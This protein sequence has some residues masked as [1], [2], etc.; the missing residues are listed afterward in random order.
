M[1]RFTQ[2]DICENPWRKKMKNLFDDLNPN[3]QDAVKCTEGPLLIL[4][5][6]GSGKTRVITYRIAYL[7][8]NGVSPWNILA[9]TFTNKAAAQMRER[10]NKL[11]GPSA[12]SVWISTYH[13]FCARVLR[14][15]A[16]H[17]GLNKD[18]TIYDDDDSKKIVEA[19]LKELNYDTGKFKPSVISGM[20]SSAKDKLLD[21]ESYGIH[22]STTPEPTS[23]GK[24]A[25]DVYELYQKK[26]K[27]ANAVDFGDLLRYVVELLKNNPPVLTKYQ[28]RFKYIMIDEYQDTNYAQYVLT[29]LLAAKYKNICVV[30]DDDQAI[31]SWRGADV[32]NIMEFERDYPKTTVVYLEQNYRSTKN[33]LE[34]AGSLISFNNHRKP[35]RLWT[36]R[37]QG[38]DVVYSEFR[39]EFN[40][41]RNVA[42]KIKSMVEAEGKS[43]SDFAVFYRTNAQ[44]R[45]FEETLTRYGIPF[46]VVGSQRFYERAEVKDILGYLKLINNPADS[47]SFKRIINIP[48]RGIGKVTLTSIQDN[49]IT[50]GK[51]LTL[52]ESAK[53]MVQNGRLPKAE[54]FIKLVD[55]MLKE[56]E[57]MDASEIAKIVIDETGYIQL[58]EAQNDI[59]SRSR[60]ENIQ[61]LVSAIVDFE[62]NSQIKTLP[63]FLENIA[64]VSD[65]DVWDEKKDFVTLITLHLAKGLEFPCVFLTG[66]EEGLFPVGNSAYSMEEL[67]EERRLCYVGMTRAKEHL[68]LS[69]A[70]QRRVY[71]QLRWCIPSRFVKE[72][73]LKKECYSPIFRDE[74]LIGPEEETA[75]LSV[76][77]GKTGHFYRGMRI[78]HPE[79]GEGKIQDVSGAADDLKV[80]VQFDAGFWKKLLVKYANLERI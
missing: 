75:P 17:A 1:L 7:L 5:G 4:A 72:A 12:L 8:Q 31:Y 29:K 6:A 53:E 54:K 64:L 9:M 21:A 23:F 65:V 79:F 63:A 45:L 22:A 61:E 46:V 32:R 40:E 76:G 77:N 50:F 28:E 26:L 36:N 42:E 16:G 70:S 74:T 3:Q 52:Y 20:I 57:N 47:I 67:E 44:S 68:F 34:T 13:S 71:G 66:L 39:D 80:I 78:K 38:S 59:E 49:A 58:L 30:G 10:I 37:P 48:S 56:K 19:S 27:E 18:F 62:Q 11:A 60:I 69:G 25:A 51:N 15:E 14:M 43:L 35:K 41:S 2:H 24:V 73:G 33:I 55:S